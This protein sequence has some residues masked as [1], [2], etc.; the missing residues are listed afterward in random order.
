MILISSTK[1]VH[2]KKC[3][4]K[5]FFYGIIGS[6]V[7]LLFQTVCELFFFFDNLVSDPINQLIGGL[8]HRTNRAIVNYNFQI[9]VTRFRSACVSSKK[10]RI[11]FHEG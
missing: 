7:I 10:T 3:S 2:I 8:S 9:N 4:P 6:L 1:T 5:V 11:I